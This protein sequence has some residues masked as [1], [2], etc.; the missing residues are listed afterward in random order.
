MSKSVMRFLIFVTMLWI[1]STMAYYFSNMW[2]ITVWYAGIFVVSLY[3]SLK[4]GEKLS[5]LFRINSKWLF[6]SILFLPLI[7][8][9]IAIVSFIFP[10]VGVTVQIQKVDLTTAIVITLLGPISEEMAFRGY[11]QGIARRKLSTNSTI[12]ITA[13]FF[14]I[15]HPFEIFPQIFV[16]SMVLSVVREISGSL[17]PPMIIHCL[18]NTVAL[19]VSF[20]T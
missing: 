1:G 5:D 19:V 7:Y 6:K 20:L 9:L 12:L 10:T 8:I 2:F 13:L 3:F 18:N 16:M 11:A 17:V 14:S 4:N 15:F